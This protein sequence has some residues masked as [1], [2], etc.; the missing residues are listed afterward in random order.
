[1]SIET[2]LKERQ[3]LKDR[4][5]GQTDKD[6]RK[7]FELD[8][9]LQMRNHGM[10]MSTLT[11]VFLSCIGGREEQEENIRNKL[12]SKIYTLSDEAFVLLTLEDCWDR[13]NEWDQ[14]L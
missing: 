10:A 13:W 3:Q 12:L 4:T 6:M 14:M 5:P 11:V 8:E 7:M 2:R 9:F 1:M